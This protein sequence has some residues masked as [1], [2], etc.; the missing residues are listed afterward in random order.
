MSDILQLPF[1]A[2]LAK[3]RNVLVA[4]A[5]GGFDVFSGLPLYFAL[6]EAGKTV[7]LANLSF[8]F[9]PPREVV[10][11]GRV[12]AALL[13]VTAETPLYGDYFPELHLARWF[14][15]QG[16]DTPVYC[17]ERTGV[18]PLVAGYQALVEQLS[19]DTVLLIDGGTD[20]LMRGDESGLGT[21]HEDI[22]S[23]AAVDELPVE[24]KM[25]ACL[26]FGVDH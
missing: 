1:F 24:Q 19:L 5:G 10:A 25:L 15:A 22:S 17:F 3:A 13:K 23:I 6:R 21:P 12:S 7:H 9:L 2:A 18:R 11:E 16:D 14:R 26:G 4:G 8:S 20:S